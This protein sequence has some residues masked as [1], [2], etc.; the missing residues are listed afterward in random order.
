MGHRRAGVEKVR[1]PGPLRSLCAASWEKQRVKTGMAMKVRAQEGPF[2]QGAMIEQM[3][4][5]LGRGDWRQR[6]QLAKIGIIRGQP[7]IPSQ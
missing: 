6:Q 2:L 3:G 5:S 1:T 4:V 7:D